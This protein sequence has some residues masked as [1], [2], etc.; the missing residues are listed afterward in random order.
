M[1][2]S[3]TELAKASLNTISLTLLNVG[4]VALSNTRRV[5]LLMSQSYPN[6]ALFHRVPAYLA[7]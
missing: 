5:R 6:Q 1:A 4:A 3:A 7:S 2:L